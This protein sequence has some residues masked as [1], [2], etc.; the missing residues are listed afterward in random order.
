MANKHTEFWLALLGLS[1]DVD[2][3]MRLWN[4]Y[5]GWKLPPGIKEN[6]DAKGVWPLWIVSPPDGG[7][8]RLTE[9]ERE[10]LEALAKT[11]GGHP[12]VKHGYMDFSGHTFSEAVDFSGLI[13]VF[14][15]GSVPLLVEIKMA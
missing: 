11:L 3:R 2:H 5:L 6:L 13:L 14:S 10:Q 1:E 7:W 12:E 15:H 4:G 9:E 8:P